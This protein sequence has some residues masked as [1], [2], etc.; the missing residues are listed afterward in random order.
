MSSTAPTPGSATRW[1]PLWGSRAEDWAATEEQQ[2]PSYEEVM[3]RLG[4]SS[5]QEVL[6]VGCGTG[7][8]L[9]AAADR[10]ALVSGLDASEA[11]IEIARRRV[12]EADLRVAD[13][14]R[15]PWDDDRFDVVAGFNSFFYAA[16]AS[17]A[18]A[19]AARVTRPGGRVVIQTWGDP[20]HCDLTAMKE[21]AAPFLPVPPSWAARPAPL[22]EPGVLEEIAGGAGLQPEQAFDVRW[23]YRY[24]DDS[25]LARALMAPAGLA[26]RVG[27]EREP[28]LRR[29]VVDALAPRRLPDGSYRLENEW[30]CLIALA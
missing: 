25:A 13:L 10:G 28:E 21:A 24:S 30:H 27:R 15:L 4:L 6:D 19:E 1:G 29:A 18:L 7:V 9:R 23:A 26:V 22:W 3:R 11:L 12:P 8:F 2:H 14:Q 20:A 5:G 16:D 17:G